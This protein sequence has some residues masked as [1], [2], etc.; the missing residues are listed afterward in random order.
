LLRDNQQYN[1]TELTTAMVDA[2]KAMHPETLNGTDVNATKVAVSTVEASQ[3]AKN[4]GDGTNDA[5]AA[6][7]SSKAN[8]S[9]SANNSGNGTDSGTAQKDAASPKEEE[10]YTSVGCFKD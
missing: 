5:T 10:E 1:K 3:S 6:N 2:L 7:S 9:Q 4:S 8:A